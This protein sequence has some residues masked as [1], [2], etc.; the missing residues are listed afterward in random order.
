MT[1]SDREQRIQKAELLVE[2]HSAELKKELRLGDLVLTQIL[3][4][5]G[6]GWIGYAAKLGP[7]NL[8]FWLAAV[9]FFYIPSA[10]VI[11]HLSTAMPLEGGLY[12]WAKLRCGEIA[13]FLVGFNLWFWTIILLSEIGITIAN[14]LAYAAGP[15]GA[16]IAESKPIMLI[17][18]IAVS[19]SLM[20]VACRGLALGKWVHNLGGLTLVVIFLLMVGLA[21]LHAARGRMAEL[22]VA[23]TVPAFTLYNL[24]IFGKMTFGAMGGFDGVAVFAGEY[25]AA[26]AGR[27]IRDSVFLSAPVV[28]LMFILGTACVLVFTK[29]DDID[30]VSPIAQIIS[31]GTAGWSLGHVLA[32][33]ILAALF[34]GR[35]A[36]ASLI[37]NATTRLPMVAGWDHLLPSWF[38]RLHLRYKTPV[39]AI[40]FIGVLTI[41]ALVLGSAGVGSQ[42][43]VQIMSNAGVILY[44]LTYLLMFAIPLLGRGEKAPWTVRLAA[45]S[46]FATTALYTALSVFPVIDVANPFGFTVKVGGTVLGINLFGAAYFWYAQRRLRRVLP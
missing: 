42:E 18:G 28:A 5:V 27:S 44:A 24:N 2:L 20:L 9:V 35:V 26:D 31:R 40:V 43:A 23:L 34:I 45:L 14:N 1:R 32:P 19:L 46:G 25:R 41:V 3:Y 33:A 7:S 6:L 8:V 13:G 15:S 17:G 4:I 37:F 11:I 16:W 30:L 36:Q 22:P 29:P 12:Q 21:L 10:I 38:S 39:G